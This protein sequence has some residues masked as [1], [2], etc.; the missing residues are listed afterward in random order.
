MK[1]ILFIATLTF[2]LNCKK[3]YK[4]NSGLQ[5]NLYKVVLDYQKRNP[6]PSDEEI[7]KKTPFIDPKNER[8]IFEL[9]FDKEEKDSLIH[10]TLEPRGVKQVYNPYG[11]YSDINL[12]PTYIIDES[13]IGKS[14]IKEYKRKDLDKFTFKDFVIND[15]MYPEYI[16]KIKG[17]KLILI[18]SIRGN[19]RR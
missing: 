11:V 18:D 7:K 17:K 6:I 9:I 19:V 10:I 13:K 8:Y 2:L 15:A 12:K 1:K 4:N 16:Y 5:D 3:E 14:F